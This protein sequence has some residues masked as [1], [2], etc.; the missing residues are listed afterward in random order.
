MTTAN[1]EQPLD[2]ELRGRYASL[3]RSTDG[4]HPTEDDWVRLAEGS[5]DETSRVRLADHVT[6]CARCAEVFRAVDHVR[7]GARA[8]GVETPSQ[9]TGRFGGVSRGWYGLALAATLVLAVAGA[10]RWS[11]RGAVPATPDPVGVPAPATDWS[12]P[13]TPASAPPRAWAALLTAPAITL[14]ASLA[15]EMRGAP[16]NAGG[17]MSAFGAAIGPYREGRY[18]QAAAA[19]D[20]VVRRHPDIAEG[21]FYLGASRLLA[22]DAAGAVAPLERAR[23]S[24]VLAAEA[25]WLGAV[26]LER[27]GR[28]PDADAALIAMC[29]SDADNRARACAA[30][31]VTP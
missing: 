22:G 21:W 8:L 17:F 1:D 15:I 30:A 9:A 4:P 24:T 16:T 12:A 13:V 5:L 23:Q 11:G 2:A 31:P 6:A 27:A 7:Q 28:G 19:L 14:P 29:A 26:A 10:V 25:R 20:G 18:A 3:Q